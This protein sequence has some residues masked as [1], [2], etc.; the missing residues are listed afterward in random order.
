[1][2]AYTTQRKAARNDGRHTDLRAVVTPS[3]SSP[4]PQDPAARLAEQFLQHRGEELG[5]ICVLVYL[6][7]T[8][9]AAA[10]VFSLQTKGER[11]TEKGERE[12][13]RGN[14]YLVLI[15]STTSR[16][17]ITRGIDFRPC[18][19]I[20]PALHVHRTR[21]IDANATASRDEIPLRCGAPPHL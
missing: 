16:G 18:A 1:M 14:V 19:F 13:E 21:R 6:A 9:A 2:H 20:R 5:L 7:N 15:I 17:C 8:V 3:S 10:A 4:Y 11:V 12:R